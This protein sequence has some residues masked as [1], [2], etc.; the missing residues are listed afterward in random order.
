MDAKLATDGK[1][2]S[3]YNDQTYVFDVFE[4]LTARTLWDLIEEFNRLK[5]N[6]LWL[7]EQ[8]RANPTRTTGQLLAL[9]VSGRMDGLRESLDKLLPILGTPYLKAGDPAT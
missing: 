6:Y 3:E 9:N 2:E 4:D 1:V 8:N 5:V 7:C